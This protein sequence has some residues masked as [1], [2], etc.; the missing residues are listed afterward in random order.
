MN[1]GTGDYM[2]DSDA[3]G[4]R[5]PAGGLAQG[6]SLRAIDVLLESESL[7]MLKS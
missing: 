2:Y 6:A 5:N 3:N 4:C 7:F 1:A